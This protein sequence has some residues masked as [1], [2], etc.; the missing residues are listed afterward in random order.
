MRKLLDAPIHPI[1][2][3]F[4][5]ALTA[6]SVAFDALGS[7]LDAPSLSAAGWWTLVATVPLTIGTLI[8]GVTSRVGLA[9]EEGAARRWLRAHMAIG[10]AFFGALL[11]VALWR[12]SLWT[13][14][15]RAPW[16]Y[17]A[18]MIAVVSFMTVQG[19]LGGELVYR[20]GADV[21]GDYPRLPNEP[22]MRPRPDAHEGSA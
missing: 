22:E 5:I 6:S 11:A 18:S 9:M 12:A 1:F 4:T 21:R 16:S 15:A 7:M 14:G 17:L 10:P 20:F 2:T 3:H 13:D 8:S 19:Y